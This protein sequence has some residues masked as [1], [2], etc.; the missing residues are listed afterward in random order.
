MDQS[1][2]SIGSGGINMLERL[3][4]RIPSIVIC[5]ANN[6]KSSIK[7]LQ[8]RKF[9]I[10][11]GDKEKVKKSHITNVV[12]D[13]LNNENKL[14]TFTKRLNLYFNKI[15]KEYLLSKRLDLIINNL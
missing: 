8:K 4:L 2:F 14:R 3:F 7:V 6:Q 12:L 9:I 1:D 13:L 10:S 11:L 5:T 15:K